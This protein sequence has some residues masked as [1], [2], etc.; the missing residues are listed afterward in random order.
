MRG[1]Y[2]YEMISMVTKYILT[3]LI[4][5]FIFKIVK[6]IYLDIKTMT[7][8]ED[9]KIMAAHFKQLSSTDFNEAQSITEIYP[10]KKSKMLFGRSIACEIILADPH[11]SS[12]HMCVKRANGRYS[13]KDL[14]SANGTF[15]NGER[16]SSSVALEDG[17]QIQL[18]STLLI[19]SDGGRANV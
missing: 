7:K 3:F 17:D 18:G 19:F 12:K 4:Y 5:L 16:I 13:L 9:T 6:L 2:M 15:V 14:G 1:D 10:I 11:V 8:W